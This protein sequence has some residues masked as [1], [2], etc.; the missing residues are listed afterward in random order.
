LPAL[1]IG[2]QQKCHDIK[3][4][5]AV[6]IYHLCTGLQ[7]LISF[8]GCAEE[9]HTS[10]ISY[11]QYVLGDPREVVRR[12]FPWFLE[13]EFVTKIKHTKNMDSGLLAY[14]TV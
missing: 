9:V 13:E 8:V 5:T 1:Y 6:L 11:W 7:L 3:S 2:F 12:D 10:F 14:G 4:Q